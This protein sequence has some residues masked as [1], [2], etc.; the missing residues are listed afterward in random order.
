MIACVATPLPSSRRF[1]AAIPIGV[2]AFP[3]PSM[4]ADILSAINFSVS[5]SSILKIFLI[6]GCNNF[7][8]FWLSP[9][10]ST[11]SNMPSHTAYTAHSSSAREKASAAEP[12]I[13][14]S[15]PAGLVHTRVQMEPTTMI[16][17]IVFMLYFTGSKKNICQ[18][19]QMFFCLTKSGEN[20]IVVKKE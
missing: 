9:L 7:A 13:V 5:G 6:K 11:S 8:S 4:L 15:T 12:S 1:M 3:S 2:E 18:P 10:A 17:Q 14:E 19:P 16:N 20:C